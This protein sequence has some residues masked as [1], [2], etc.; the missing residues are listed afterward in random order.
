[1]KQDF[2][3]SDY[4]DKINN[5]ISSIGLPTTKSY[6]KNKQRLEEY[7]QQSKGYKEQI[8][9]L[10]VKGAELRKSLIQEE[11]RR[12]QQ[13]QIQA[14]R[15]SKA[16]AREKLE[17]QR[18]ADAI[19][20]EKRDAEDAKKWQNTIIDNSVS[21]DDKSEKT[22]PT[23]DDVVRGIQI[24]NP[25]KPTIKT[26]FV[27]YKGQ[28]FKKMTLEEIEL[29]DYDTIPKYKINEYVKQ[30]KKLDPDY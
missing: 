21:S 30:Y 24:S 26:V 1:M 3:A 9:E 20:Q 16:E 12:I 27:P 13:E 28:N 7:Q 29:I 23:I 15:Q 8:Y 17:A 5:I 14:E 22:L 11:N 6:D 2:L 19:K 18:Q 25:P 4:S 10:Q